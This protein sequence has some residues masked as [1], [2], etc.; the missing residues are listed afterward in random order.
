MAPRLFG[1]LNRT[2][3][4][5]RFETANDEEG[6]KGSGLSPLFM[7]AMS[8]N[9]EVARALVAEHKVDV[10]GQ[11]RNTNTVL[12]FDAGCTP[13]H[14]CMAFNPH[15]DMRALLLKSGANLNAPSRSGM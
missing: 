3:R 5:P 2:S 1:S 9:V 4:C 14:A 8:G 15:E 7:A 13:L 12:G 6:T 11:T 10:R